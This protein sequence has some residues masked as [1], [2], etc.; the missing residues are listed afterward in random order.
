MSKDDID[1]RQPDK[2]GIVEGKGSVKDGFLLL[3]QVHQTRKHSAQKM[4]EQQAC[5]DD[6]QVD[7]G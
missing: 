4:Q 2:H 1:N 5:C 7:H 6:Q 3:G